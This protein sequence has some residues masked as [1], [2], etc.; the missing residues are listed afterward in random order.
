V[1]ILLSLRIHKGAMRW[2]VAQAHWEV[3]DLIWAVA[4]AEKM[5]DL[6]LD[7]GVV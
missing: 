2:L 7:G 3:H 1:P 4:G 6:Q 5:L